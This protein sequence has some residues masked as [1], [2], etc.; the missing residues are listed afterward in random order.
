MQRIYDSTTEQE[1][2]Q[3]GDVLNK[4]PA[5][6]ITPDWLNTVQEEIAGVVEG[7]GLTL[8]PED[9]T[10]LLKAIQDLIAPQGLSA[11]AALA[12]QAFG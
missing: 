7:A 3:G 11:Q 9:N 6:L 12:A 10:Q 2:F 1:E 8:D 5:T 4:I